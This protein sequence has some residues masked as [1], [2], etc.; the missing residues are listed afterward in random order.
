M[1]RIVI[2]PAQVRSLISLH[3]L[4]AE[5]VRA[6][7]TYFPDSVQRRVIRDHAPHRLLRAALDPRRI[8]LT[9]REGRRIIGYAIGAAPKTGPAQLFWLYVDPDYRGA[10]TGLS[11]LSRM[12]KLLAA[13]GAESVTI[14]THDH[15]SYYER[16]GFKFVEEAIVD[17]VR[18][19]ILTFKLQG[20]H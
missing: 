12:L 20:H 13:C 6:H 10:N 7:F 18:M 15:R 1:T 19:D 14:A 3:Q 16:Q 17:G 4:F 11:L 5:A 9:A 2:A 8:V